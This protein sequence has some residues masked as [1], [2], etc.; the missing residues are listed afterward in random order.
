LAL[1]LPTTPEEAPA[2]RKCDGIALQAATAARTSGSKAS[3]FD[4]RMA[5]GAE[6]LLS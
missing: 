5:A 1:T 6:P 2:A 3:A 4:R